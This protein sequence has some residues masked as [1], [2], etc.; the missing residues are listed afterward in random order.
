MS[1]KF[2]RRASALVITVVLT[3]AASMTT[4]SAATFTDVDANSDLG[5]AV[6]LLVDKGIIAGMGDGTFG[7]ARGL[8]RAEVCTV[9][10]K[11][12]G[13]TKASSD[14]FA[15]VPSSHWGFP[16]IAVGR[17]A[18]YIEGIGNNCFGPD[19]S[20]TVEQ[21][22]VILSKITN[23]SPTGAI[24]AKAQLKTA[25]WAADAVNACIDAGLITLD[26]N[27]HIVSQTVSGNISNTSVTCSRGDTAMIIA[28]YVDDGDGE[29]PALQMTKRDIAAYD[30]NDSLFSYDSAT[31]VLS[32]NDPAA[33]VMQG[34]DVSEHQGTVDWQQVKASG[35]QFVILRCGG[36][37]YGSA[38]KLYNDVKF[39]ENIKG[40]SAAGLKIGIY[41]YAT[42]VNYEEAYAEADYVR[43]IIDPYKS[44]ITLPVVYDW[45]IATAS[46]RN[47]S[48]PNKNITECFYAF[49]D[50]IASCGYTPM[51][52]FNRHIGNKLD[53]TTVGTGS[54]WYAY[55]FN[56]TPNKDTGEMPAIT[57]GWST[58]IDMWQYTSS[59]VCPGISGRVDR[60]IAIYK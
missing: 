11:T 6:S 21:L 38:G 9:I 60:N 51:V 14:S 53:L 37:G 22:C 33:T 3:F 58:K 50:R 8:T 34:I 54:F 10:N 48:V 47:A 20:L 19:R 29:L 4:A 36:R 44:V 16:Y 15:D 5:R 17:Q 31:T 41:F 25:V 57:P 52:Y 2:F 35:V 46:A 24:S 12:F 28:K 43:G 30:W 55:P 23:L 45:E 40:A 18:G 32:Y 1:S 26:A 7:T 27:G 59:G 39:A 49:S 42:A 13:Y 56:F